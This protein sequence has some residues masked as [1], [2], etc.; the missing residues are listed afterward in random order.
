MLDFGA[1]PPEITSARMYAGPGSGPLMAA[2]AAWDALGT[3]LNSVSRGYTSTISN[4]QG[5][6]WTGPASAAMAE[7]AAP[8]A[9]WAAVTG[10]QAEQA[11]NQ[12]RAAAAAYETAFAATV[13]PALV[14]ANRTQLAN[15]VATN[16]LGQNTSRIAATEAAYH[17]MWAQDAHA[18]Y[19]YAA[20]SSTATKL[21]PFAEP[22]P[23]TDAAGQSAQNAAVAN[24]AAAAAHSQ[25]AQQMSMVPQNLQN[26]STAGTSTPPTPAP[27][28]IPPSNPVL[29]ATDHFNT[30][31]GPEA[32]A[33]NNT[34]TVAAGGNLISGLYRAFLQSQG[35]A[36]KA[37]PVPGPPPAT[38]G[39]ALPEAGLHNA[40]LASVGE[41]AP[42]GQLSVP[43]A[44]ADAT[45]EP[46]AFAEPPWLSD[47]ELEAASSWEAA[48]AGA[49]GAESTAGTGPMAG[50]GPMASMAAAAGA[51]RPTVSNILR[52]GPRRF[53]MP[54]PKLGG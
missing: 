23:T 14:T 48:P 15:L 38:T 26:L 45:P 9:E 37:L 27:G 41:A 30:L 44:W 17:E 40:V 5:E 51:G 24:A 28:S 33:T 19:G 18:M 34:R 2:A 13:P 52:V 39:A 10:T 7:A 49:A 47:T 29:T 25:L 11:A 42:V 35:A 22:P 12:L 16:I 21:T 31:T 6:I 3:Q 32:L 4:L 43:Q 54:R 46:T 8:Y 50:M 20:S 53:N 1:L 36:A